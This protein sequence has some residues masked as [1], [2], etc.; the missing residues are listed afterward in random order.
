MGTGP[1]ILLADDEAH[2]VL[3]LARRL[4]AEGYRLSEASNGREALDAARREP[5]DLIITDLQMPQMS[6]LELAQVL[7]A[8]SATAQIPLIMLTGRGYTVDSEALSRTNICELR[9]K[10]FSA[11]AI[12]QLV[13]E[14]LGRGGAMAVANRAA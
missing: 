1:H 10:P 14:I 9:P 11:R 5:P 8:D 12:V 13:A 3:I 2:V 6:G 7:R 4:E